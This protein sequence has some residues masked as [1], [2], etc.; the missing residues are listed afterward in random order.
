MRGLDKTFVE[1]LNN[2]YKNI[3]EF[4]KDNNDVFLGIRE[5]YINLYVDGGSILKL[6]YKEKKNGEKYYSASFDE[7]YYKNNDEMQQKIKN[8][9]K[10][11]IEQWIEML[12]EFR[13]RVKNYQRKE[14]DCEDIKCKKREKILQQKLL[15]EFNN[16][17]DYFAYDMEYAIESA[18]YSLKDSKG[19][20]IPKKKP[21]TAGRADIL[22]ISKPDDKKQIKIYSMEVKHGIGAFG[23]VNDKKDVIKDGKTID[24]RSFGS[25]IA[26]HLMNNVKIINSVRNNQLYEGKIDLRNNM[27]SEVKSIMKAYKDLKLIKNSNF[28]D[29]N[30]DEVSLKE[31]KNAIEMV[32]FLGDYKNEC[33]SFEN[34]LGLNNKGEA[35]YSVRKLLL[36]KQTKEKL[37]LEFLTYDEMIDEIKIRKTQ[38]NCESEIDKNDLEIEQYYT[39]NKES[40]KKIKN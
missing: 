7:K 12:P 39:I 26:G 6:E 24:E 10:K 18:Q 5:N 21:K 4:V 19:I 11:D 13:K 9:D 8:M 37:D 15:L 14:G 23:G 32:F 22:L 31:G 16:N 2:K 25:G 35:K 28:K 36:D 17:S 29:I 34:Y 1:D 40:F 30:W 3:I 38:T 33:L 27:L 20:I